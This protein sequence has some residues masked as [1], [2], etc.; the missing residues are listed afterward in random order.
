MLYTYPVVYKCT[1]TVNPINILITELPIDHPVV[2]TLRGFRRSR[3]DGYPL[4][5]PTQLYM[6]V[7]CR[8]ILLA[9]V[10]L[11]TCRL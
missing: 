2:A 8:T 6:Y 7:D 1:N 9:D 3:G 10:Q 5:T 4:R 11:H